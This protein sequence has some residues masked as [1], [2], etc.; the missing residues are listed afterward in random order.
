[1]RLLHVIAFSAITLSPL[2][3]TAGLPDTYDYYPGSPL[4]LG[5]NFDPNHVTEAKT[6]CMKYTAD[7]Q[8]QG[9]VN[10]RFSELLTASTNGIRTALGIDSSMDAQFL[11]FKGSASFSYNESNYKHSEDVSFVLNAY[12]EYGT[13]NIISAEV[14]NEFK[15]LPSSP[16]EFVRTCGTRYVKIERRGASVSAIITIENVDSEFKQEFNT[17]ASLAGEVGPITA[18][19]KSTLKIEM[20]K[21]STEGRLKVDVLSTGGEGFGELKDVIAKT[22]LKPGGYDA[23]VDAL[24]TYIGKFNKDNAAPLAFTVADIPGLNVAQADL[25]PV[26]KEHAIEAL[27]SEYREF[28]SH[29]AALKAITD[30]DDPRSQY[31]DQDQKE[32]LKNAIPIFE[33]YIQQLAEI[34]S[35]CK[36]STTADLAP[37]TLPAPRPDPSILP[38]PLSAPFGSFRIFE[39]ASS[40]P[41]GIYWS[42]AQSAGVFG[43]P[44]A[45]S[46]SLLVRASRI[47]PSVGAIVGIG[48]AIPDPYFVDATIV[49]HIDSVIDSAGATV[50][51]DKEYG[52]F[53]SYRREDFSNF[54]TGATG[55]S[56]E[57]DSL[58]GPDGDAP[59]IAF[60]TEHSEPL[61]GAQTSDYIGIVTRVP[62]E[63]LGVQSYVTALA[64][65]WLY[66]GVRGGNG[67]QIIRLRNLASSSKDYTVGSFSWQTKDTAQKE[68]KQVII[69]Y[70][71]PGFV[72]NV[73]SKEA[74]CDKD[75]EI[76]TVF[77]QCVPKICYDGTPA[78]IISGCS[79]H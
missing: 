20:D 58:H 53:N 74:F 37:C 70:S 64:V 19:F 2:T 68:T 67:K 1:M 41:P 49:Y 44:D 36:A 72:G 18:S 60:D 24:T 62:N 73:S 61:N 47:K 15:D 77:Q 39:A 59:F 52:G 13:R 66:N 34:H 3:A 6:P 23:I 14:L 46:T 75:K 48:F 79:G 32:K 71:Y 63:F 78:S 31:I 55:V 22:T 10:T 40:P 5:A 76:A 51:L 28:S 54:S 35:K 4:I 17:A 11:T 9:A 33:T 26:Q 21:A 45:A 57:K 29:L 65:E 16:D 7:S 56:S 30:D 12:T 42:A 8:P 27:V 43:Q 25:W 69:N 50:A 38:K